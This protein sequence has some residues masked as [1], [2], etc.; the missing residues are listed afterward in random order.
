MIAIVI[1]E[2]VSGLEFQGEEA[3]GAMGA[4]RR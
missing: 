4:L 2:V 3:L 1:V